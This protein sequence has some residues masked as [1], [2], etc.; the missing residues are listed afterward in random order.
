MNKTLLIAGL[1]I[2]LTACGCS[3]SQK[4]DTA[5]DQ[6]SESAV[7]ETAEIAPD[8]ACQVAFETEMDI[9]AWTD[10]NNTFALAMLH[11][12]PAD[13]NTVFSPYSIERAMGMVLDGACG[14]TASELRTALKEV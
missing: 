14:T 8:S 9:T 7:T 3:K 13:R 5:A 10:A 6:S 2:A 11:E 4:T 12:M 1:I